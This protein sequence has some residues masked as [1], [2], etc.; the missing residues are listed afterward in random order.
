MDSVEVTSSSLDPTTR[1]RRIVKTGL[2]QG[3]ARGV[4]F[5]ATLVVFPIVLDAIGKAEFGVWLT[6]AGVVTILSVFDFGVSNG[7]VSHLAAAYGSGDHERAGEIVS[8]VLVIL[9]ALGAVVSVVGSA[10]AI[11]IHWHSLV[12]SSVVSEADLR[13]SVI[14]TVIAAG[15]SFPLSLGARVQLAMQE[16]FLAAPWIALAAVFEVIGAIIVREL[17]PSLVWF[18]ASFMGALVAGALGNCLAV[19]VFGPSFLRPRL[20]ALRWNL[21]RRLTRTGGGFFL[22]AIAATVAYE[23]DALVLTL[24]IG[25]RAAADYGVGYRL[26]F[27]VPLVSALFLGPLWPAYAEAHARGDDAWVRSTFFKSLRIS[28]LFS[29]GGA[30]GIALLQSTIIRAWL[31]H[32]IVLPTSLVVALSSLLVVYACSGPVA[33]LLNG[34]GRIKFQ[35]VTALMMSL[36]NIGLSVFLASSIGLAGPALGTVIAQS[37]VILIPSYLLI[38]RSVL[39]RTSAEARSPAVDDVH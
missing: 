30:I 16:G 28:L 6:L 8:S 18:T 38:T 5:L 25:P 2:A 17:S 11:L 23:T 3:L 26:F 24:V 27:L 21:V 36:L 19:F 1:G 35:V 34:V 31:G 33:M 32:S 13:W 39:E 20:G 29:I 15:L 14:I 37:L 4:G 10:F 22:L 12:D 7:S 9:T